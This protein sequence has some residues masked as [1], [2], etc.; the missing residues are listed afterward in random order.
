VEQVD[1]AWEAEDADGDGLSN[2]EEEDLGTDPDLP[3]S[4]GDSYSDG[5]EVE[6]NTDPLDSDDAPYVG[7]WP[8]GACRDAVE[9]T[10]N[11]EGEIA[12]DFEL[13]DQYGEMVRLHDF[14][15]RAVLLVGSAFW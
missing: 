13:M 12:E 3:D 11:E 15:D 8:I 7:G 1:P 14:C 5:E 2:G 10:G 4:D 9:S 6:A